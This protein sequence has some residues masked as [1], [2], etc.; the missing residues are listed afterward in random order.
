MQRQQPAQ[1]QQQ[2][3]PSEAAAVSRPLRPALVLVVWV[4]GR[5]CGA[6][7]DTR[8]CCP[9]R[10]LAVSCL[11]GPAA[12]LACGLLAGGSAGGWSGAGILQPAGHWLARFPAHTCEHHTDRLPVPASG[13][14]NIAL[15]EANIAFLCCHADKL[16]APVVQSAV[17]HPTL[18]C[19]AVQ[20]APPLAIRQAAN[21]MQVRVHCFRCCGS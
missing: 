10:L 7:M 21:I 3:P 6:L 11:V 16:L 9:T 8:M 20:R 15:G 19:I 17:L 18:G 14:A 12:V 2:Q 1:Q 13:E 5:V 4:A